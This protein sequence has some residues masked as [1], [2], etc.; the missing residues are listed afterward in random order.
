MKTF[1]L[2]LC[3][4]A[5]SLFASSL[6]VYNSNIALVHEERPLRLDKKE[7][8]ISY[9]NVA[10]SII[11]ESINLKLPKGIKLYSQQYHA[12]R[13]TLAKLLEYNI[14]KKVTAEGASFTLLGANSHEAIL[15]DTSGHIVTKESKSL[16]FNEVP[17]ELLSKPSLIWNVS[18]N[19]NINDTL[20]LDYLVKN[21]SWSANYVLDVTKNRADLRGFISV[22]NNTGKS[23]QKTTL[24]VLAGKIN[25][26]NTP[27]PRRVYAK[28]LAQ[29]A[30]VV[31]EHAHEGYHLYKIPFQVTLADKEK[32]AINFLKKHNIKIQRTYTA[33]MNN[34]LFF[35]GERIVNVN[36]YLTLSRLTT[37][38][39]S[40]T[41]RIYSKFQ[42]TPVLLGETQIKHIPKSEP[43]T[44]QTGTNFDLKVK[45]RTL[46]RSDSKEFYEADI[47]YIVTN[48]SNEAKS[49]EIEVPF[50]HN[51][52][53]LIKSEK[54]YRFTKGNL[55]TFSI[56]VK[57]NTTTHFDVHFESSK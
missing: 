25:R 48:R 24:Y 46:K 28:M 9:E 15:K 11:T 7:H 37:P 1:L 4:G 53:A 33:R 3:V 56:K 40:G 34:P 16:I 18:T 8:S 35:H 43:L 39:P 20:T 36:Q 23:F 41:V 19:K 21:I 51:K 14:G 55:A 38:L 10:P 13:L 47:R 29:S 6:V 2:S 44:L 52:D 12:N 57:A 49:I 30:P 22:S 42:N 5:S 45:E 32:T 26:V 54:K 50:R 17:K 27:Q 31:N